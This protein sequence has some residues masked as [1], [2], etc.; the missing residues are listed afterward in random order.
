MAREIQRCQGGT[1][2]EPRSS[3]PETHTAVPW[4][5]LQSYLAARSE[6]NTAKP[7]PPKGA[8]KLVFEVVTAHIS[9]LRYGI[10]LRFKSLA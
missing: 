2:G 1:K 9:R 4:H 8:A 10:L 3:T 7:V 5:S 6:A